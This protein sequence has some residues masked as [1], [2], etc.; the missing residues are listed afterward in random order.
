MSSIISFVGLTE[1]GLERNLSYQIDHLSYD[2]LTSL[3]SVRWIPGHSGIEG[4]GRADKAV[5]EA[6]TG[7]KVRTAKRSSLTHAKRQIVG[8]G[9]ARVGLWHEQRSKERETSR[10][11]FYI[12]SLKTRMHP[13]FGE[14]KKLYAAR[15]Y[16]LKTGHGA[17]ETFLERIGVVES[18]EC[19]W[20]GDK[21]QSVMH[22]YTKCRKWRTE[23]RILRKEVGKIR[24]RWQRRTERRWLAELLANERTVGPLL[25]CLKDTEVGSREGAMEVAREWRQ[26]ND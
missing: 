7:E 2:L 5:K 8:G 14:A 18:A 1:L 25:V 12:P 3:F 10:R 4:N 20:C 23:R 15:F 22:L 17:I 26:R 19:W 6:T 21:E 13:A 24:V 16:Q 11:G 9:K